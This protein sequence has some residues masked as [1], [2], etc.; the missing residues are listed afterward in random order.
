MKL[1][2]EAEYATG[3]YRVENANDSWYDWARE[4]VKP[5]KEDKNFEIVYVGIRHYDD[6]YKQ[7]VICIRLTN[8]D[9]VQNKGNPLPASAFV[10]V[11]LLFVKT[12]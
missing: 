5:E 3:G 11:K 1:E 2:Y 4:N 10:M 6:G 7:A 8:P 9:V 12:V